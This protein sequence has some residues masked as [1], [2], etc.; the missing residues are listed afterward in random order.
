M[1]SL[2]RL[3]LTDEKSRYTYPKYE[4]R[5]LSIM[6]IKLDFAQFSCGV[7]NGIACESFVALLSQRD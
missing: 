1:E 7:G 2:N 3:F 5:D 4:I 6:A